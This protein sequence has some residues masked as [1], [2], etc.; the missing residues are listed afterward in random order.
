MR[1]ILFVITIMLLTE[2]LVAQPTSEQKPDNYNECLLMYGAANAASTQAL[3]QL[4]KSCRA[5]FPKTNE[6]LLAEKMLTKKN[7]KQEKS[8]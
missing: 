3:I 6:E 1:L 5:L 2:K 4:R 8:G 7:L